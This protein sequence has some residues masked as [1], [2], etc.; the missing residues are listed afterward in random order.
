MGY[1]IP[2]ILRVV[3]TQ[4]LQ[5]STILMAIQQGK[6]IMEDCGSEVYNVPLSLFG[7]PGNPGD[8]SR[9]LYSSL[10]NPW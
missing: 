4:L 8:P 9:E 6:Q 3:Y 1:G 5:S 2:E 10:Q 7:A